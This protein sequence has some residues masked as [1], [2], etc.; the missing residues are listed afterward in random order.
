M[1]MY[2]M[3]I[4]VYLLIL[5]SSFDLVAKEA[6]DILY[7]KKTGGHHW[8]DKKWFINVPLINMR[9]LINYFIGI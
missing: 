6:L 8:K 5:I 1:Q 9:T 3:F 4:L 7:V 2:S